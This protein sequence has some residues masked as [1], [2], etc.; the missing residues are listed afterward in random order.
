MCASIH[1]PTV[2][3]DET[4]CVLQCGMYYQSFSRSTTRSHYVIRVDGFKLG[5]PCTETIVKS[6]GQLA[7]MLQWRESI[8][9]PLVVVFE[10]L[11][12][13]VSFPQ[14]AKEMSA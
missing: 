13:V 9:R 14:R 10:C 3:L 4:A 5:T 11:F 1:M 6:D 2:C 7:Q 12:I 8:L